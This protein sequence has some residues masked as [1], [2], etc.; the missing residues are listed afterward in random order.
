MPPKHRLLRR[1][2]CRRGVEILELILA[3]PVLVIALVAV[4]QFGMVLVVQQAVTAAVTGAAR[5]AGK[6]SDIAVVRTAVE[7]L[8]APHDIEISNTSGSGTKVMLEDGS[9][10]TSSFGDPTLVCEASGNALAANEVRVTLCIDLEAARV[11]NA[12]ASFGFDLFG[13]RFESSAVVRKE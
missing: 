6:H 7:R 2:P 10:G 12:L 5:E 9:L 13:R 4:V 1:A 3:L 8:L 11:P